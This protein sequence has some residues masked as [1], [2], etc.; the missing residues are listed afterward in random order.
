MSSPNNYLH[1]AI[2]SPRRRGHRAISVAWTGLLAL[3]G[4]LLPFIDSQTLT[5][6]QIANISMGEGVRNVAQIPWRTKDTELSELNFS[7]KE[8][9]QTESE[10]LSTSLS[11]TTD[12]LELAATGNTLISIYST[13]E[14]PL[15]SQGKTPSTTGEALIPD[16][17]ASNLPLG[18]DIHLES[19]NNSLKIVGTYPSNDNK[20][21][22]S[23]ASA[24]DVLNHLENP[25]AMARYVWSSGPTDYE[26]VAYLEK[27]PSSANW[28]PSL[29]SELG[30]LYEVCVMDRDHIEA[31]PRLSRFQSVT[32]GLPLALLISTVSLAVFASWL[33]IRLYS[34]AVATLESLGVPQK[35]LNRSLIVGA[36]K[37]A[38]FRQVAIV[39]GIGIAWLSCFVYTNPNSPDGK[40][41]FF[42]PW[43]VLF[44]LSFP[45]F[46]IP[47]SLS[48]IG[49]R[50][51]RELIGAILKRIAVTLQSFL[52]LPIVGFGSAAIAVAYL[53]Q[54]DFMTDRAEPVWLTLNVLGISC[55]GFIL[56]KI[57]SKARGKGGVSTLWSALSTTRQATILILVA[58]IS[59][60]T[61]LSILRF[62]EM[63]TTVE[64]DRLLYATDSP[65]G[66]LV[67]YWDTEAVSNSEFS[68]TVIEKALEQQSIP[69]SRA[70][71][72]SDDGSLTIS[73]RPGQGI[74]KS[75]KTVTDL[76]TLLKRTLNAKERQIINSGGILLYSNGI[77]NQVGEVEEVGLINTVTG[78]AIAE[79]EGIGINVDPGW[80]NSYPGVI[81]EESLLRFKDITVEPES[82]IF[83][84]ESSEL[85]KGRKALK[86]AGLQPLDLKAPAVWQQISMGLRLLATLAVSLLSMLLAVTLLAG[87][88]TSSLKGFANTLNSLGMPKSTLR[89]LL[90]KLM[91]ITST[92]GIGSALF[93]TTILH[94]ARLADYPTGIVIYPVSLVGVLI[95]GTAIWS[96]FSVWWLAHRSEPSVAY[97]RD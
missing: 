62:S 7:L 19:T 14:F 69:I 73:T 12:S 2:W 26:T 74:L 4:F 79:V 11:I 55:G 46:V 44:A 85:R 35:R 96:G 45:S 87:G 13:D 37:V 84:G 36:G 64:T 94:Y 92:L 32:S 58:I 66:F 15:T 9:L 18:S 52:N 33:A 23:F 39:L 54:M 75:V 88:L 65:Q 27:L 41:N 90:W 43:P 97:L 10:N 24:L 77:K 25:S 95:F 59:L 42:A 67:M 8:W 53:I 80:S 50:R 60:S 20:V 6:H 28:Y 3:S 48:L 89:N 81:L 76:E 1:T 72:A 34:K 78:Q 57:A 49:T 22:V 82:S 93:V 71:S 31:Y 38:L 51:M 47:M 16:S 86:S 5:S 91:G 83:K 29:Y 17:L 21:L 63:L 68:V 56:V 61:S 70:K 40:M 30:C